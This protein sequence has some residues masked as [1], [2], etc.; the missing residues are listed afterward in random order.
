MEF[1]FLCS[2]W[3]VTLAAFTRYQVE[4]L[5][6]NNIS[7]R[8]HELF[9]IYFMVNYFIQTYE[10]EHELLNVEENKQEFQIWNI[11]VM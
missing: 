8:A 2:T 1:L 6:R 3:Y 7:L 11:N 4:H 10:D 5:K 9:F